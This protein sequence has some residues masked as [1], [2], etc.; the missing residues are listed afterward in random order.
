MLEEPPAPTVLLDAHPI[1]GAKQKQK[2][3]VAL[4]FQSPP[5]AGGG[6]LASPVPA[7][8]ASSRLS[9]VGP[10]MK[11]SRLRGLQ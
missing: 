11:P 3:S 2:L 1:K 9:L 4:G 10:A 6:G 7:G 5:G 8:G